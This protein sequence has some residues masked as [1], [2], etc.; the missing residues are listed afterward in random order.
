M[1]GKAVKSD[2]TMIRLPPDLKTWAVAHARTQGKN[3]AAWVRGLIEVERDVHLGIPRPDHAPIAPS[4]PPV[5]ES[6]PDAEP[7]RRTGA[8]QILVIVCSVHRQKYCEKCSWNPIIG[9]PEGK[10]HGGRSVIDA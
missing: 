1:K 10:A 7:E 2:M 6:P 5:A 4:Q 9:Y 3:L 8:G